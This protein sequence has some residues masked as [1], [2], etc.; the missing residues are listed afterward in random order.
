MFVGWFQVETRT[1]WSNAILLVLSVLWGFLRGFFW[2]F[3]LDCYIDALFSLVLWFLRLEIWCKLFDDVLDGLHHCLFDLIKESN[4][5]L[6]HHFYFCLLLDLIY[7]QGF[8]NLHRIFHM[9]FPVV[10]FDPCL[11]LYFLCTVILNLRRMYKFFIRCLFH[12]FVI[13]YVYLNIMDF[14]L[15]L[16]HYPIFLFNLWI[17]QLE[18]S[19]EMMFYELFSLLGLILS[20]ARGWWLLERYWILGDHW[21]LRVTT[22]VWCVIWGIQMLWGRKVKISGMECRFS[23]K[24]DF[25]WG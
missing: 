17:C 13:F 19:L 5:S 23:C 9:I 20:C 2:G 4:L 8:S 22:D 14:S 25:G 24:L 10:N 12:L 7:P 11:H 3:C 21:F 18:L 6:F 1:I 16:L 15:V